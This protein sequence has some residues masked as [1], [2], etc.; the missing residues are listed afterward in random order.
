VPTFIFDRES[1]RAI[2]REATRRFGMPS[3]LL[4]ENAAIALREAAMRMLSESQSP[5]SQTSLPTV[6]IIC[7]SGNNGGDGYALAR[8]LHNQGCSVEIFALG[9]PREGTDARTYHDICA[10]MNLPLVSSR[11][12]LRMNARETA[13]VVD[14]IFGTGLDRPIEPASEHWDVIEWVNS[15]RRPVLAAD[16]P[17]GLDCDTGQPLGIAIRATQTV[18]FVGV[19]Q[20]FVVNKESGRYTGEVLVGEIGV[21]KEVVEEFGERV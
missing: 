5:F 10:A 9:S 14:A 19:K 13:L 4:M 18:S 21:P 15:L 17:S 20:G 8:H 1:S 11:A 7:G 16:I 6:L 3:I 12:D 2:D